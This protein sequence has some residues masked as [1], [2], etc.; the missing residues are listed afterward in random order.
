V[1]TPGGRLAAA[2]DA[3]GRDDSGP[4]IETHGLTKSYRRVTALSECSIT[5]PA[6]RISA[7]VGP[8]GA[9]KTTLLRLLAGLARPSG[10]TAAVRGGAPRQGPALLAEIGYRA[11]EIPL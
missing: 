4:A 2:P 6:G 3:D 8:N 10:G 5:V 9:G 1:I 7:L 11:P